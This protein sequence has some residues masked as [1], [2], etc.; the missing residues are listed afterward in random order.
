MV[1][2]P[3]A[4]RISRKAA[5]ATSEPEEPKRTRSAEGMRSQRSFAASASIGV[6]Y[7]HFDDRKSEVWSCVLYNARGRV[8]PPIKYNYEY[9]RFVVSSFL[10]KG[11][12][13]LVGNLAFH[14]FL[15]PQTPNPS[16]NRRFE[17]H[18]ISK[19]LK[20]RNWCYG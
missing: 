5:C 17:L 12:S 3:V 16:T 18:F 2:R 11:P 15:L 10:H 6:A 19:C 1:R 8:L 4:A 20:R 7:Q 9:D 14:G 13:H